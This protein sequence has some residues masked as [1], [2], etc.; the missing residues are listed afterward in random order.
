MKFLFLDNLRERGIPFSRVHLARLE[1]SGAFPKRV[2]LGENRVAWVDQE[3]DAWIA[4]R[5]AERESP[6]PRRRRGR[7]AKQVN[8]ETVPP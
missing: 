7:Q 6:R 5:L 1:A 2:L 8:A 3:I 4:E